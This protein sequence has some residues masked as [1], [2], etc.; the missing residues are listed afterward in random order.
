MGL[1]YAP[2]F[3]WN[4]EA[5]LKKPKKIK[6]AYI[7]LDLVIFP[8]SSCS[9]AQQI[10]YYFVTPEG[11][12]VGS[13]SSAK[14][15]KNWLEE[16]EI[17]EMDMLFGFTGDFST[18]E[19]RD[20]MHIGEFDEAVKVFDR[21][22]KKYLKAVGT[23]SYTGYVSKKSGLENFRHK[24][25]LRK[26]YKGNRTGD[27]PYYLEQLRQHA[28]TYSNHKKSV[29]DGECDDVVCGLAQRKPTN[30]LIQAEKDGLQCV[31]CFIYHPDLHKE[32]V[33]SDPD[34]CG[35]VEIVEGNSGK[36][37]LGLGHLFL[38]GQVLTGDSADTY[39]GLDGCGVVKAFD[40]L[41]P[42]NHASVD[43]LNKAVEAVCEAY[44][45]KYGLSYQ[46]KNKDGEDAAGSWK[47][48]LMESLMLAYMRK[49]RDDVIPQPYADM[50]ND[51]E[52]NNL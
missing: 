30:V 50:I 22:I 18:L 14:A 27:K 20:R 11:E 47:D 6:H 12:E 15:A 44:Y 13:F 19:R 43:S 5:D 17:M 28:L 23:E 24:I 1:K 48:F 16:C 4:K 31:G 35:Y 46:Y 26:K 21:T 52:K 33:W 42:F 45:K 37:L 2:F 39:S 7:D 40:I 9:G 3:A 25:A 38:L 8:A 10:E 34:V 32:P 41:S 51:W 36:K 49:S 29:G